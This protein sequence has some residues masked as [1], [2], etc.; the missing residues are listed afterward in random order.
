[1]EKAQGVRLVGRLG[2]GAALA[3]DARH[4]ALSKECV[5]VAVG[6]FVRGERQELLDERNVLDALIRLQRRVQSYTTS[7]KGVV[8]GHHKERDA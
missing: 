4:V 2:V 6:V 5:P 1:M 8:S 7:T 3:L